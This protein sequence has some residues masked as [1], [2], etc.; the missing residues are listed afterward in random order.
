MLDGWRPGPTA[1]ETAGRDQPR[2][3]LM[4]PGDAVARPN[5]IAQGPDGSLCITESVKGRTWRVFYRR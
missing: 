4:S 2:D 1:S 3:P 5:G